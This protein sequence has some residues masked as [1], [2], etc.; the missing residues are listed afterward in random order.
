MIRINEEE[1]RLEII[2]E[3]SLKDKIISAIYKLIRKYGGDLDWEPY[4]EGKV[5]IYYYASRGVLEKAK[6]KLEKLV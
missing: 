3:E 5:I 2:V 1:G 6:E 4:E